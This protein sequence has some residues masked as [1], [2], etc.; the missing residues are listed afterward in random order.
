MGGECRIDRPRAC[1]TCH[2]SAHIQR[3]HCTHRAA[4]ASPHLQTS[5]V[6][7]LET[8]HH[9][10]STRALRSSWGGL[11]PADT[12]S[13][14]HKQLRRICVCEHAGAGEG[15]AQS[16]VPPMP[17]N[18]F[19]HV[20]P[21]EMRLGLK[22]LAGIDT[23]AERWTHQIRRQRARILDQRPGRTRPQDSHPPS[24]F[25]FPRQAQPR[26]RPPQPRRAPVPQT[27]SR[28]RWPRDAWR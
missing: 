1:A 19:I 3:P 5:P 6:T 2:P 8:P 23:R 28:R 13:L 20:H 4:L 27:R 18:I 22:G 12:K 16:I 24:S 26:P 7:A 25:S 10:R 17:G 9:T 21:P 14:H 11:R 15:G